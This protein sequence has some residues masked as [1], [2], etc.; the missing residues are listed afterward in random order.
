MTGSVG[1]HD[2]FVVEMH[3]VMALVGFPIDIGDHIAVG[4]RAA[5]PEFAVQALEPGL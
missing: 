2:P 3:A 5:L 1:H 4:I